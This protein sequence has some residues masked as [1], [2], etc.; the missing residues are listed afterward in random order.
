MTQSDLKTVLL[1]EQELLV[2]EGMM[3]DYADSCDE[4]SFRISDD[5]VHSEG[6]MDELFFKLT[7]INIRS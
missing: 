7:H 4:Y 3:A 6:Q 5:I 2:L 1:T